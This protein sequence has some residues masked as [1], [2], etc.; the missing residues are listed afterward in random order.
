MK[1]RS[2]IPVRP[3]G[4]PRSKTDAQRDVKSEIIKWLRDAYAL[5]RG[6]EKGLEKQA[7]HQ[8]LASEVRRRDAAHLKEPR[9]HAEA[10]KSAPKALRG[11]RWRPL[12]DVFWKSGM[13]LKHQQPPTSKLQ[14]STKLQIANV[15]SLALAW[16]KGLFIRPTAA[17]TEGCI[18]G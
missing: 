10:V 11:F 5:E 4:E 12:E 13:K 9:H 17:C 15:C 2:A 3:A 1:K 14:R 18:G 7:A 8:D 6:S 16:Q